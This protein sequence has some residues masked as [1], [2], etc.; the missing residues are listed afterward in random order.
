MR[1]LLFFLLF[2]ARLAFAAEDAW[3]EIFS[4]APL[5]RNIAELN[6][7]NCVDV[8][9]RAFPSNGVV[10]ALIFMPGATDELNFFHRVYATLTNQNPTLLDAVIALTNQTPLRATFQPPF[11]LIHSGE[12]V[13]D[14]EITVKHEATAEKLKQ[15]SRKSHL[16]FNDSDWDSLLSPL[17]KAMNAGITPGYRSRD[18]WHFYRNCFAAWNLSGWET[19]RAAALASKAKVVVKRG[20]IEFAPDP[21]F[22]VLPKL[23]RFPE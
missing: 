5:S 6:R 4:H 20:W 2:S 17:E 16:V 21:R 14:L 23:E 11:L 19:L 10:K 7:T 22:G 1:P 3:S 12:D 18:A 13:L 8:M 15:R 9:L